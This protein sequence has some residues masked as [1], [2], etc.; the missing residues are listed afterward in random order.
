[1]VA[2][3]LF[4]VGMFIYAWSSFPFVHWIV[5]LIGIVI[6]IWATFIIYSAVFSYLA[7]W[8]VV[9]FPINRFSID[10]S[11][12][13]LWP[14][15][16]FGSCRP[17]ARTQHPG[18]GLPFVYGSDVRRYCTTIAPLRSQITDGL[19]PPLALS[20][21]WA[22]TLLALLATVMVPI[23]YVRVLKSLSERLLMWSSIGSVF[24]WAE[25]TR[26]EQVCKPSYA[27]IRG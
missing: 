17:V 25:D 14:I 9:P 3:I 27:L 26:K 23:P 1:M 21:K 10:N 12:P 20:Y 2:A 16:V 8:C 24:L 11:G 15:C 18:H 7:D 4:P 6:F 5:L 22:N 13:Q 19:F